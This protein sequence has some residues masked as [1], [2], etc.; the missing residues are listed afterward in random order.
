MIF[1]SYYNWENNKDA[2][3]LFTSRRW[4]WQVL[5]KPIFSDIQEFHGALLESARWMVRE[6][7]VNAE[8]S[9]PSFKYKFDWVGFSALL[10]NETEVENA[11]VKTFLKNRELNNIC[12]KIFN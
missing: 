1:S 12:Q 9:S 10:K 6:N 8:K 7:T 4:S 2:V 3:E 5:D 11:F